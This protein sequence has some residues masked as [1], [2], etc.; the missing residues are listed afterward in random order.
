MLASSTLAVLILFL[1]PQLVAE[2]I[3]RA[4]AS[5]HSPIRKMKYG[6][7]SV[8]GPTIKNQLDDQHSHL[9]SM[10]SRDYVYD[11]EVE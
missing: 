4:V 7:G 2:A 1:S 10:K 9:S 6:S 11:E 5:C 8:K 3:A